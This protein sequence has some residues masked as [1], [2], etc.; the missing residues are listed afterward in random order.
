M[1]RYRVL[2]SKRA[3]KFLGEVGR[4]LGIRIVKQVSDLQNFPFLTMPHDLLVT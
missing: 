4:E 2:L 3:Y 1:A